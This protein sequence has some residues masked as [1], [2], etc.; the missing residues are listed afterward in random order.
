MSE[1]R[2]ESTMLA[3][4]EE[5]TII[6]K[7]MFAK[8]LVCNICTKPLNIPPIIYN[9]NLGSICGRC[10]PHTSL[11]GLGAV[12]RQKIYEEL[13]KNLTFPC[14]NKSYGCSSILKWNQVEQHEKTCSYRCANCPLSYKQFFPDKTCTWVGN[15]KLLQDHFKLH[16]E[17]YLDPPHFDWPVDPKN[18]VFLTNASNHTIIVVLKHEKDF[19]YH[20]VLM[21]NGTDLESQCFKYQLELFNEDKSNSLVLR[22]NRLEPLS[23][24]M[25]HFHNPDKSLEVDLKIV[26]EMLQESG[27]IYAK[28]G[29]VKKNKKDITQ[30]MG[31]NHCE[32]LSAV[33]KVSK[34]KLGPADEEMLSELECPVCNEYMVPPIFIC[35]T[36]HSVCSDCKVK[37]GKCP[38]CR[39]DYAEGRNFTLEKLTTLVKYPC[40][41][42]D[43]GCGFISTSDKI[44]L[45]QNCCELSESPCL[46]R[47]G[48]KGLGP[49]MYNHF[50]EKH[51]SRLLEHNHPILKEFKSD[52]SINLDFLY[53]MGE[54]FCVAFANCS[55]FTIKFSV[56]QAF[57]VEAE[58]QYKYTVEFFS[59]NNNLGPSFSVCNTCQHWTDVHNALDN[60][61]IIPGELLRRVV[62]ENNCYYIKVTITKL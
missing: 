56:A 57:P 12:L 49:G 25:D 46:L 30:I 41:N 27:K 19:K 7:T 54:I 17:L 11:S 60:S 4:M 14:V 53:V 45:H 8:Q 3:K 9:E 48:W 18:E 6:D 52:K 43:I 2:T 13:L 16:Q 24:F 37:V 44:K 23:D 20:C 35:P 29:I 36:G 32:I 33:N 15:L 55:R 21:V 28:F 34:D 38:S 58:P 40:R 31:S 51:P 62:F 10:G 42:R 1:E 59:S 26:R 5:F 61:I 39:C 47:C 50:L 22:R